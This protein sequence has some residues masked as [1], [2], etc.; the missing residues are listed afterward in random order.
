MIHWYAKTEEIDLLGPFDEQV[1]A[2]KVLI[3][4]LGESGV[5][6]VGSMVWPIK[7]E[8][9]VSK[10]IPITNTGYPYQVKRR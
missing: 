1:E 5:P 4:E 10:E 6:P 3:E 9:L 2:W 8:K 7:K